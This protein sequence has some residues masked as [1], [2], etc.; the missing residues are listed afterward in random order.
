M[1][2]LIIVA[3]FLFVWFGIAMLILHRLFPLRKGSSKYVQAA[4]NALW[5][6][7]LL[8]PGVI[9]GEGFGLPGPTGLALLAIWTAGGQLH[10]YVYGGAAIGYV[11][12][13]AYFLIRYHFEEP[14]EPPPVY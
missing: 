4:I 9:G 6:T 5:A 7:L 13:L 12:F 11:V 2:N 14:I 10:S 3:G 1:Y 8:G